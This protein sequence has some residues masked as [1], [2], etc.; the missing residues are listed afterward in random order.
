MSKD[1]LNQSKY[2]G[3]IDQMIANFTD[4]PMVTEKNV[5]QA[6]KPANKPLLREIM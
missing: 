2:P 1:V 6:G 4:S 3:I 5:F